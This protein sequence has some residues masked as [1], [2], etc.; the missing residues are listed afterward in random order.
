MKSKAQLRLIPT[1]LIF[2]ILCSCGE[3][4]KTELEKMPY[5]DLKG[6]VKLEAE[7]L[8]GSEVILSSRVQGEE[9]REEKILTK[10]QWLEQ[11]DTF[12]QSDINKPALYLSYDTKV[13]NNNVLIHSLFEDANEKVKE[14]KITYIDDKVIS[15]TLKSSEENFFYSTATSAELYM[16]NVTQ[17]VDHYSIETTQKIWF[18]EPSNI[19]IMGA[20]K[21]SSTP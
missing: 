9:N 19:K 12:I 21:Q 11:F 5:F 13:K 15:I 14:I 1:L 10:S 17:K 2:I 6:F 20:I 16:N 18:L 3:L 8:D 7:K 4:A